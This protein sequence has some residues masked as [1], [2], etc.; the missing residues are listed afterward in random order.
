MTFDLRPLAL[1]ELLDRSFSLYRRHFWMFVGLMAPPAA[2][3]LV[4]G[5]AAQ[6]FQAMV[7]SQTRTGAVAEPLSMI[8]AVLVFM[9]VFIA[10]FVGYWVSVMAALGASTV[11]VSELYVDRPATIAGSFAGIRGRIGRLILLFILVA[12][13]FIGIFLALIVGVLIVSLLLA[14]VFA[15]L[16]GAAAVVGTVLSALLAGIF[17]LR[18][19]VAVPVAVLENATASE[20]IDRSV[21]LTRGSLGRTAVLSIFTVVINYAALALLQ[22][23]FTVAA[24]MIGPET[25]AAFWLNLIGAIT[26]SIAR[27]I[28]GPLMIV[29]IAV[30]YYDLRIRQEGLDLDIMMANLDR[31]DPAPS[32]EA[33]PS[34]G[35]VL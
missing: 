21:D 28:T 10:G 9:T 2:F 13:R 31:H 22:G 14:L 29:A 35:T 27:A 16:G 6:L 12:L 25:R 33:L 15:P 24:V 1:G 3:T 7:T 19:S 34:D 8:V 5:V 20:S 32:R 26:G 30:L 23:P 4:L 17:C 18:Y 11:A